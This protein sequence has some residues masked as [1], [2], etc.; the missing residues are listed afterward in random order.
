MAPDTAVGKGGIITA[1]PFQYKT[2]HSYLEIIH[3]SAGGTSGGGG[4]QS[5]PF[6][7]HEVDAKTMGWGELWKRAFNNTNLHLQY[8]IVTSKE[9]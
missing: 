1:L 7:L 9:I 5:T 4:R 6:F 2:I 3:V 8:A